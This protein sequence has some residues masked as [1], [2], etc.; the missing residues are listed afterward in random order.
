MSAISPT[1]V[2]SLRGRIGRDAR[3]GYYAAP[4]RYRLHLSPSCPHCLRIAVTHSLLGLDDVLPVTLLPALP[5]APDGGHRALR[6]L[7]EA[8]SHQHPGPAAAPVLSDDWT[9]TIVSTHAPGILRD[10][11]RSFGGHG[12]DLRPEGFEEAVE[13]VERL[14]EQGVNEAA[15]GAGRSDGDPAAREA[16]LA[17][18]LRTLDSLDARLASHEYAVG[19]QLTLADVELWASLVQLDAVHRHHL[20]AAAVHRVTEHPHVW[21]YARRLTTLPAFGRSLDLDALTQRHHARCQGAEAAG[22]A[23]PIVDW[24][25]LLRFP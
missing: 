18:L 23:V 15:Q 21:A 13:A 24:Q 3:S 17:L 22:A 20:D 11:V 7:Y 10:L 6:P 14:C 25:A 16:A 9:G 4:R 12:P 5:D 1:V 19:D 2:P 8:S